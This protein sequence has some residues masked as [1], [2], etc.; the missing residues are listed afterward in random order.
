MVVSVTLNPSIDHAMFVENILLGDTNRVL[1]VERDAGG[2]GVNLSR[3]YAELGGSTIA[4]GFLGGAAA[5]FI[6]QVLNNE[7]VQDGFVEISGETRVNFSVEDNSKTPPTTFNELGPIISD[8]EF[9]ALKVKLIEICSEATWVAL[10]GS[11]PPGIGKDAFKILG[12]NVSKRLVLDADGEALIHGLKLKPHLIKPNAAEAS[13]LLGDEITSDADAL[14]A[15]DKLYKMIGG[16]DRYALISRGKDGAVMACQSGVYIGKSPDIEP[17][18][19]IGSG[20]SM[21]AGL[22]WAL[23][24]GLTDEEA[25]RW[26]LSAGAATAVTDGSEI[27]RRKVIEI[28]FEQSSVSKI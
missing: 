6:R 3:V 17:K 4:T 26:G 10:G 28:L 25:L 5:M 8:A 11:I 2:K 20:D 19:T 9:E 23:D 18:S 1:R 13:R 15:V 24:S 16:E 27:G 21:I 14:S 22:L 12:E 7:N